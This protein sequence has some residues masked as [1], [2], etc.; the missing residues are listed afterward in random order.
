[1]QD[2]YKKIEGYNIDKNRKILIVINDMIVD[3]INN[4]KLNSIVIELFVRRRTL[5]IS[6]VFIT[7]S[8]FK[9]PKEVRL[10]STHFFIMKIPNKKKLKQIV[11]NNSSDID[12]KHFI[13]I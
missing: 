1:M 13:K 3:V 10:N 9:F 12:S 8:Y 2:V 7:R 4:K 6:L 5:N 11:L